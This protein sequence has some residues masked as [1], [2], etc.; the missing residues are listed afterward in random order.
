MATWREICRLLAF[1]LPLLFL[2][3]SHQIA[4]LCLPAY[5]ALG[6]GDR[7]FHP[8]LVVSVR[9][10]E[11]LVAETFVWVASFGWRRNRGGDAVD[12]QGSF[13]GRPILEQTGSISRFGGRYRNDW[14]ARTSTSD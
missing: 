4:E 5:P 6:V 9:S 3:G 14:M 12:C 13:H 10:R 8:K 2:C 7:V 11:P 1:G